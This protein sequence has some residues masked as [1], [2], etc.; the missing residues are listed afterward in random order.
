MRR[1]LVLTT[2]L[3][4]AALAWPV[5]A[6]WDPGDPAKWVQMPDVSENGMYVVSSEG[7]LPGYALADDFL[8]TESG[9]INGIH[10]WMTHFAHAPVARTW[11]VIYEDIPADE[12][13]T[14]YSMPGDPLW[15]HYVSSI[16]E[17][18]QTSRDWPSEASWLYDPPD[19]VHNTTIGGCWQVN[20]TFAEGEG[21]FQRG[22]PEVPV[23]YWLSIR[24]MGFL[25]DWRYWLCSVDHW[26]D[27]AVWV[28]DAGVPHIGEW[29]ELVYPTEHPY[30]GGSIDLAFVITG[31]SEE[32]DWG[33]APDPT[34]PTLASS[35]GAF[36]AIVPGVHLG[37]LIDAET[38]GLPDPAA[39]GDDNDNLPDE[40]GVTFTAPLNA[41]LTVTV[42]V[43]ASVPGSLSAWIDFGSDGS[44]A[45]PGDQIFTSEPLVAG[46]NP[47]VFAVPIDALPGTTYARFRFS[48]EG[49]LTYTGVAVDGEIEDYEVEI[50][51]PVVDWGD[52]PDPGYPTLAVNDGA[53]HT[54]DSALIMGL[55]IDDEVDGQP[56][57]NA[58]GDDW[59]YLDDED[60]V[61]FTSRLI[62]GQTASVDVYA[63]AAGKLNAWI[64]FRLPGWGGGGA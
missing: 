46:V 43:V 52:A 33:D 58:L 20:F 5:S 54:I 22:S 31:T 45:E 18:H 53:Y 10:M 59:A 60:G 28:D 6:D 39:L 41:G 57:A 42:D 35:N 56:D 47:L 9:W 17:P 38:N 63:S 27:D 2:I 16:S 37:A 14:G 62:P 23:V 30:A 34:Y 36:H 25:E 32:T 48:T 21:F 13:P 12:S 3:L 11:I 49:G 55:L 51:G 19:W 40:D 50:E 8:C 15:T 4:I 24:P 26:N 44:W 29:N 1:V 61:V 7:G 64:A